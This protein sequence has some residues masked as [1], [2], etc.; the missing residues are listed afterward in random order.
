MYGEW[1]Q[2]YDLVKTTY[3][4]IEFVQCYSD[5][6]YGSLEP[7]DRNLLIIDDQMGEAID[8]KSLANLFT[9]GSYHR[10]V[11][12]LYI[13]QNMFD[14][15]KSSRTVSL[16]SHYIVAFRN[17]KDLSQFGTLAA[18]ILPKISQWIMDAYADATAKPY[19]YLV[20]NN[21]PHC[22]PVF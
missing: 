13:V 15:G 14:Q 1:Q 2:D 21:S 20:I 11:T 8:T 10:N 3:S 5:D 12:I 7:S 4:D 22:N 18:R 9:K 19:G 6:I 16:N 17:M